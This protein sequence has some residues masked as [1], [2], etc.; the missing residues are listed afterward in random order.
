MKQIVNKSIVAMQ[1]FDRVVGSFLGML[2]G[3]IVSFVS[4]IAPWAV[5]IA[6]AIFAGWAFYQIAIDAKMSVDLAFPAAVALVIGLETVG[7]G[8]AHTTLQL[9][10]AWQR[11]QVDLLRV[12][13]SGFLIVLY[14]GAGITIIC[15]L[16]TSSSTLKAIGIGSFI[17]ALVSYASQMLAA[18]VRRINISSEI[19]TE[20][21]RQTAISKAIL[22]E[23]Q[24]RLEMEIV[25]EKAKLELEM[26]KQAHALTL[27][28]KR[29]NNELT[30]K[31]REEKAK[32]KL[33][34]ITGKAE[35]TKIPERKL[36]EQK[37]ELPTT[38]HNGNGTK[39]T[40]P[41]WLPRLP[42]TLD[43]FRR[44]VLSGRVV[45]PSTA[46]GSELGNLLGKTDKTGRNYLR[47]GRLI[48]NEQNASQN[49]KQQ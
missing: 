1:D 20:E 47:E 39:P 32:S 24:A 41:E 43:D 8:A 30:R 29:K 26:A 4:L 49:G 36:P 15:M 31:L 13:L 11:K 21:E 9:Y 7:A 6:P 48:Q 5:P 2:Q 28:Q 35:V 18:D 40:L 42:E 25:K 37:E 14:A 22:N 3:I 45:I 16:E 46:T 23:E 10:N 17:L 19:E 33:P 27:E 44:M 12:I 38:S 34:E